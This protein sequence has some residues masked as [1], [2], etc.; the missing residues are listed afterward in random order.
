LQTKVVAFRNP[1]IKAAAVKSSPPP[2]GSM[3][4]SVL[5]TAI[6]NGLNG[7]GTLTIWTCAVVT[8]GP[9]GVYNEETLVFR[10]LNYGVVVNPQLD[11]NGVP[12]QDGNG[13]MI[14]LPQVYK[15]NVFAEDGVTILHNAGDVIL[16]ENDDPVVYPF[17]Y[18]ERVLPEKN[19]ENPLGDVIDAVTYWEGL[20]ADPN[21]DIVEYREITG[22]D[23]RSDL[24]FY[25]MKA[26][27]KVRDENGDLVDPPQV[28]PAEFLVNRDA[29]GNPQH[30]EIA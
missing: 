21:S 29:N 16:D 25:P 9:I 24:G 15:T 19:I 20:K 23:K 4:N 12:V 7:L 14:P 30:T 8:I 10:I 3:E 1:T 22:A 5:V 13:N 6:D 26:W 11:G 17:E 18:R 2:D 28:R 27:V